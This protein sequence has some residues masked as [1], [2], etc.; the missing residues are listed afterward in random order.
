MVTVISKAR[1][2]ERFPAVRVSFALFGALAGSGLSVGELAGFAGGA[3]G[4]IAAV[5]SSYS[6]DAPSADAV[7]TLGTIAVGFALCC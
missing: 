1:L 7:E 6:G 2:A 4:F 5:D 3:S